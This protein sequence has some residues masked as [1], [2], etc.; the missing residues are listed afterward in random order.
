[1]KSLRSTGCA[2]I[3]AFGLAMSAFADTL[4]VD[5]DPTSSAQYHTLQSACSAAQDGDTI[6]CAAG[7]YDSGSTGGN[8]GDT[9]YAYR[10]AL[11]KGRSNVKIVGA[12]RDLSIIQ[13]E[14]TTTGA[15]SVAASS[16]STARTSRSQA[17]RSADA[18][19]RARMLTK[20]VRR[21]PAS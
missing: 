15:G 6:Q 9:G 17:S 1:M 5:P 20:S 2:A 4:T 13:G 10:R 19:R 8:N 11:L 12:G 3:A 7:V 18:T 21:A 14:G 16:C